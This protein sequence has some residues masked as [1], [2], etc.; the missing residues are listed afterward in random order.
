MSIQIKCNNPDAFLS[1]M[2]KAYYDGM[3]TVWS[4]NKKE[5]QW[6]WICPP[7]ASADDK[8]GKVYDYFRLQGKDD[9]SVSFSYI[10]V[11]EESEEISGV[12]PYRYKMAC[13]QFKRSLQKL[14]A[15]GFAQD[16]TCTESPIEGID[17]VEKPYP[18]F[19]ERLR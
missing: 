1:E 9:K 14:V 7:V 19:I 13:E 4:F 12:Y 11:A 2:E 6:F 17:I 3:I 5:K 18:D 10:L 16:I 15:S 8:G